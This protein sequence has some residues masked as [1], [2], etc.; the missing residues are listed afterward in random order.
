MRKKALVRLGIVPLIF[1]F[2]I[3]CEKIDPPVADFSA[4]QSLK[5]REIKVTFTDLSTNDPIKR[6]WVFEGGTPRTSQMKNPVITYT[7]PGSFDVK[8]ESSNEAGKDLI[9]K[10]GFVNTAFFTNNMVTDAEVQIDEDTVTLL[11][12]STMLLSIFRNSTASCHIETSGKDYDRNKKGILLNWNFLADF[13][14]YY[15]YILDI[16]SELVFLN[17]KNNSNKDFIYLKVNSGNPDFESLE[18]VTIPNNGNTYGI[19]YY[20]ANPWMKIRAYSEDSYTEWNEHFNFYIPWVENQSVDLYI[21]ENIKMEN[22]ANNDSEESALKIHEKNLIRTKEVKKIKV[23]TE[24][25][26]Q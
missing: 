15:A 8:L 2:F 6:N 10:Y 3:S 1:L 5:S 17:I 22:S 11:A 13:S 14:L 4:T 24:S 12:K 9:N 20:F 16:S 18:E 21:D 7:E 19:G 23:I 26:Y 25:G